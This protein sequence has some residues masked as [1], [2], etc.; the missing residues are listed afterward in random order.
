MDTETSQRLKREYFE[1]RVRS[2]HP[3]ELI[4]MLYDAAIDSLNAAIGHLKTQDRFARSRD[5]TRA[6][7]AVHE[8]LVSLDHSVNAPFTRT[9]AGLYRFCLERMAD[10]HAHQSEQ[11]FKEA[12]SVLSTLAVA[13]REIATSTC[14]APATEPSF[15]LPQPQT[16][17]ASPYGG[18]AASVAATGSRDWSC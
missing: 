8:L 6:Q 3:L 7:Q 2:A 16:V 10:G 12:L 18:Y 4:V 5:V 9:L 17:P 11:Q 15:E 1:N 13:W 14:Q